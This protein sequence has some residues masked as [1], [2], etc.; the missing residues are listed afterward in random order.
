M[1]GETV[2]KWQE[3]EKPNKN[4]QVTIGSACKALKIK[5]QRTRESE[6]HY[7]RIQATENKKTLN[8]VRSKRS[9]M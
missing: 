1:A 3:N 4:E 7:W 2:T 5:S 6:E 9:D 8:R